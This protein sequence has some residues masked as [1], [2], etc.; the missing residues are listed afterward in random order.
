MFGH[1]MGLGFYCSGLWRVDSCF[2]TVAI[3]VTGLDNW[4]GDG[5]VHRSRCTA[6]LDSQLMLRLRVGWVAGSDLFQFFPLKGGFIR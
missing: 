6:L 5:L 4:F 2:G 3:G 1:N